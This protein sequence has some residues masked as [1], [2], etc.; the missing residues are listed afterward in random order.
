MQVDLLPPIPHHQ[1]PNS[2]LPEA[3][4]LQVQ[5][6]N[7]QVEEHLEAQ[8]SRIIRVHRGIDRTGGIDMATTIF[9][10]GLTNQLMRLNSVYIWS[11]A[12]QIA[13]HLP[14]VLRASGDERFRAV[15]TMAGAVS[16]GLLIGGASRALASRITKVVVAQAKTL[17]G[18]H[19]GTALESVC[20]PFIHNALHNT[21][22]TGVRH[23]L[24]AAWSALQA[25]LAYMRGG[26]SDHAEA[27]QH[28]YQAGQA[29]GGRAAVRV[30][31]NSLAA[32]SISFVC[33]PLT[34]ASVA[35]IGISSILIS[36]ISE[37]IVD[38]VLDTMRPRIYRWRTWAVSFF[39]DVR[40][41]VWHSTD[42]I[43][44]H[45][46]ENVIT[47]QLSCPISHQLIVEPIRSKITGQIYEKRHIQYWVE[48]HGSD[49]MAPRTS[50]NWSKHF[51]V[52]ADVVYW[53]NMY[54]Q[55]LGLEQR[56]E[57]EVEA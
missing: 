14:A 27:A 45:I 19:S 21:A 54:K 42:P 2:A 33:G 34:F 3:I 5:L 22:F 49:P 37:N 18:N 30:I 51:E 25:C 48:E 20:A 36:R 10:T 40:P 7:V 23:G 8:R 50:A 32:G 1:V 29:F 39:R 47:D 46:L 56:P 12:V 13:Y 44:Q 9:P 52:A 28:R 55:L 35:P 43:A 31:F 53:L 41:K 17:M 24:E 16:A 38:Y 11:A 57:E 6:L 15:N 26:L 4:S